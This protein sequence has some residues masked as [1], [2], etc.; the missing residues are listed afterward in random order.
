MRRRRHPFSPRHHS[1]DLT[2]RVTVVCWR[3]VPAR[4]RAS[5]GSRKQRTSGRF[6]WGCL[7]EE[8]ANKL[9]E[10]NQD[11]F[12]SPNQVV[13]SSPHNIWLQTKTINHVLV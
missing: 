4:W 9:R 13:G 7:T 5:E 12:T 11:W 10:G 2:R 1:P 6:V 8:D 3:V